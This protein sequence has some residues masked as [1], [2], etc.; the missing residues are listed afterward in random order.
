MKIRNGFVS[1]SSSSS[2]IVTLPQ[3]FEITDE[4]V[5]EIGS[6]FDDFSKEEIQD[7]INKFIEDGYIASDEDYDNFN[8]ISE[9]YFNLP[10][11][12]ISSVETSGGGYD[13][14]ELVTIDK[15]VEIIKKAE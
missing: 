14:Y 7:V 10:D 12:V 2:F 3:N 1:N 5:E 15:L 8:I 9:L 6:S 13:T 11:F 4:L